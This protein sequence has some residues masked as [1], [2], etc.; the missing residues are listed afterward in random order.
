[1]RGIE[2]QRT[3]FLTVC[4]VSILISPAGAENSLDVLDGILSSTKSSAKATSDPNAPSLADI[5]PEPA[6]DQP[7]KSASAGSPSGPDR[8]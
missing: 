3:I 6:Q 7:M 8:C 5:A 2:M 4:L 1:M